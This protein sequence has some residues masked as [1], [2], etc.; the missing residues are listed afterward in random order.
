MSLNKQWFA[1]LT[2]LESVIPG[3]AELNAEVRREAA[4]EAEK[5][6]EVMIADPE[7]SKRVAERRARRNA[8]RKW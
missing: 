7:M 8:E 2:K 4:L 1:E 5:R 6:R 3:L